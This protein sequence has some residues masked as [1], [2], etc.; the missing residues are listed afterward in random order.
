M[1]STLILSIALSTIDNIIP[2]PYPA[3]YEQVDLLPFNP[4]GWYP[5]A[6]RFE[7]LIKEHKIKTVVEI[8]SWLGCST[9]HIA[10]QLPPD[11]K[12]Y[13]VDHWQGSEEHFHM[14]VRTWI[15]TLY[16]QFLSNV[17]HAELTDKIIPVRMSSLDAADKFRRLDITIDLIY[18]DASHDYESV[19]HD[20]AAWYPYVQENGIMTG[21][22]WQH[23]PIQ[24]AVGQFA[25]ENNLDVFFDYQFWMFVK[26][27]K[28]SP[29]YR[30]G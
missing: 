10:S 6:A 23:Y 24:Q 7:Q 2:D 17:V 11:G 8:G 13:A 19:Y 1:L 22:D 26:K 20:I 30:R 14:D 21:D 5:H 18:I 27:P 16:Q 29:F 15:P 3:V 25:Q 4:H 28:P 12:V 9:R